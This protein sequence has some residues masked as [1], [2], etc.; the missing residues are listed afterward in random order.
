M[1]RIWFTCAILGIALASCNT[2][3]QKTLYGR[4]KCISEQFDGKESLPPSPDYS[5]EIKGTCEDIIIEY[6][7]IS[8]DLVSA[9]T[10]LPME[11]AKCFGNRDEVTFY[12]DYMRGG[13]NFH[14]KMDASRDTLRGTYA[15][16]SD[17]EASAWKECKVVFVR[18]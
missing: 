3:P 2:G 12:N 10:G 9:L 15:S 5:F 8:G 16:P 4:W 13:V 1:S 17:S 7:E 11:N 6:Y 14:L 18:E